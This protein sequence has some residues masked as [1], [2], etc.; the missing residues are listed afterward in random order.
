VVAIH[1]VLAISCA[2]RVFAEAPHTPAPGSAERKAIA[3]AMRAAVRKAFGEPEAEFV[4]VFHTLRVLGDWAWA[5]AEPQ[6]TGTD[7][8]KF[9]GVSFLLRRISGAWKVVETLPDD[10]A[11][12][13]EPD[14]AMRN[15]LKSV[16]AKYPKLPKGV[17]PS[18]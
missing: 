1:H 16:S 15:W 9:E 14:K 5:E 12:A 4:F 18:S 3:D 7:A 6:R 10:V 8:G 2:P 17:L 13:D 11:S